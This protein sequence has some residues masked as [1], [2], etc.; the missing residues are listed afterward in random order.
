MAKEKET[1]PSTF[2]PK[3]RIRLIG[4]QGQILSDRLISQL[5]ELKNG[6][7]ETHK[8]PYQIEFTLFDKTDIDAAKAYMDKL[9][10]DLPIEK[11]AK[12]EKAA[13]KKLQ[14]LDPEP[15]KELYHTALNKN[16]KQDNLIQYLRNLGFV[17]LTPQFIRDFKIPIE[18][19]P[20][21]EER[22]FM[23]RCLKQAK[24]PQADKY[25]PQLA[26]AF[27]L[28]GER[29]DYLS[30]YLYGKPYK[31]AKM[32]WNK[33]KDLNYKKPEMLSF[34]IYMTEEE[35]IKFSIEHRKIKNDPNHVPSKLYNRWK[36]H[37]TLK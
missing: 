32:P 17:F 19:K 10:G 31:K 33:G 24:N 15:I 8:G 16:D 23:V 14:L 29:I 11:P 2:T 34:P 7:S 37:I 20:E 5:T 6:P 28:V 30:I 1:P 36:D 9:S 27:K 18:I 21:H 13:K 4:D 22:A 12:A 26:F 3:M 35:R 25:D